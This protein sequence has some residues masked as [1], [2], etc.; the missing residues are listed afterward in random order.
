MSRALRASFVALGA[1]LAVGVLLLLL[2]QRPVYQYRVR[3]QQADAAINPT[4]M[5]LDTG[6]VAR[7]EISARGGIYIEQ[8]IGQLVLYTPAPMSACVVDTRRI[9]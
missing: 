2:P 6:W 5:G 7:A 1:A 4:A 9:R 3:C 8:P